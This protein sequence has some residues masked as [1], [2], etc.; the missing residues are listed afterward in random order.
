MKKIIDALVVGEDDIK[1][2]P[3]YTFKSPSNLEAFSYIVG[4][5]EAESDIAYRWVIDGVLKEL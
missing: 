5:D 4:D 3:A 2:A 1:T